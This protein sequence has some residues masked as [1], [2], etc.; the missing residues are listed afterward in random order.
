MLESGNQGPPTT[1][2]IEMFPDTPCILLVRLALEPEIAEQKSTTREA[3]GLLFR[4][5]LP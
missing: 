2:C 3:A 4:K 5:E 1:T